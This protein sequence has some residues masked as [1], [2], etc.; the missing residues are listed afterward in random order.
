MFERVVKV[1]TL[2]ASTALFG[3][4]FHARS[5]EDYRDATQALLET[6]NPQI[7]QCYNDALKGQSDLQGAVGIKFTV[8][9]ETG[10]I[11]DAQVDP[12]TTNA[13]ETLSQCVLNAVQGLVLQ[14]PDKRDGL[15]TFV[16]QFQ[17][18]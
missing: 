5:A 8:Q 6:R 18:G 4:S 17:A 15:A 10:N 3:C 1:V 7:T 2:A 16:Y 14:P 11:I 13:P 12:A 9:S